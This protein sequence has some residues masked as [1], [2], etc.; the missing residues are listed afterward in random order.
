MNIN[1][2]EI[3]ALDPEI[4]K[5]LLGLRDFE[6]AYI[7]A[8]LLGDKKKILNIGCLWGR[9]HFFLN[10]LGKEV[11]NFDLGEQN[12][13]NLVVGD[14]TKKTKFKNNEFD[15]VIMGDVI[16]HILEDVEALR[17]VRRILKGDGKLII[18]IPYYDD[19]PEYHVRMHS[20]KT[21]KRLL[22]HSGFKI[23][24]IITRG[25]LISLSKIVVIPSLILS[26]INS[27]K[28]ISYLKK[29]SEIDYSFGKKRRG[30]FKFSKSYGG[31]FLAT[32]DKKIDFV[33]I[34][35]KEFIPSKNK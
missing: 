6:G 23:N 19:F 17:E 5:R 1:L 13:P 32:K 27:S 31:Y 3:D 26:K 35:R 28:R 8:R 4:K 18:T 12:V 11:K 14:I 15:A 7:I 9:D 30:I 16:E 34:N 29:I 21:M 33:D 25:G 2:R 22:Q 10:S 24:K 20:E